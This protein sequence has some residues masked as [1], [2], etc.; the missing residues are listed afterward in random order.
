MLNESPHMT[1]QE[2]GSYS[3]SIEETNKIRISLGLKPLIVN[4]ENIKKDQEIHKPPDRSKFEI[5]STRERLEKAKWKRKEREL[6]KIKS[7][8]DDDE[9]I[10]PILPKKE[11]KKKKIEETPMII[12]H[13][14]EDIA[15]G[16][17]IL[18]LVDK[19]VLNDD[20]DEL[21]NFDLKRKKKKVKK[22]GEEDEEEEMKESFIIGDKKKEE[23]QG[24]RKQNMFS[25]DE[26]IRF[27]SDFK[28]KKSNMKKKVTE[29]TFEDV[30]ERDHGIRREKTVEKSNGYEKALEKARNRSKFLESFVS[31]IKEQKDEEKQGI[32]IN[33]TQEYYKNIKEEE[34]EERSI[35]SEEPKIHI[36]EEP[37]ENEIQQPKEHIQLIHEP[38][39]TDIHSTLEY[40]EQNQLI[41]ETD[42]SEIILE[43]RD[44]FGRVMTQKQRFK[45]LAHKYHGNAP[46]KN[47]MEKERQKY[48]KELKTKK[49]DLNS[50]RFGQ[51]TKQSAKPYIDLEK[52]NK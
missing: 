20:E 5:D 16:E 8:G 23:E 9:E 41:D 13:N 40:I 38:I 17:M 52:K 31:Q 34:E 48:L 26:K 7:L 19:T 25:L 10:V 21:E 44:R 22:E 4:E 1:L 18:T 47:K 24:K 42:D 35:I 33:S 43:E 37:K 15:E 51:I 11:N 3:L 27:T 12:N 6:K 14:E 28:T 46:G 36:K 30:S 32:E 2:D 49:I 29:I 50:D 39:A 45:A